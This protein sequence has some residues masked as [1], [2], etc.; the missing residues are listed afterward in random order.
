MRRLNADLQA[1]NASL[2]D[3]RRAA[4][5]LMEDAVESRAPGGAGPNLLD[6]VM[7][8]LTVGVAIIDRQGGSIQSNPKF[9]EIWGS[10]RPNVESINDYAAFKAW[11]T[12]TGREVAP[13]EWASA[14]AV[15]A[16]ETVVDQS[17]RI[18]K[19]D[20]EEAYVLNS[21]APIFDSDG[22]ISGSAVTIQDITA[23][24]RA[25]MELSKSAERFELLS[26]TAGEL[27]RSENPPGYH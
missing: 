6:T 27:L 21:A 16:G 11:F 1:A 25:E 3:S 20:G 17:M 4:V 23:L 13:E 14:R 12:D 24:H 19:F 15:T 26:M 8:T 9:E 7:D 22:S 10:N 5:N 18:R 2:E